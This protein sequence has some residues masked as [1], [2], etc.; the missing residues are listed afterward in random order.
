MSVPLRGPSPTAE[1]SG[2]PPRHRKT[3]IHQFRKDS[4]LTHEDCSSGATRLS[5]L[6][7]VNR[8]ILWA[9]HGKIQC[10]SSWWHLWVSQPKN[11]ESIAKC[12]FLVALSNSQLPFLR[13]CCPQLF[14][15]LFS[16]QWLEWFISPT[17]VWRL[18]IFGATSWNNHAIDFLGFQGVRDA[19]LNVAL[20]GVP[21]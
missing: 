14:I 15:V 4:F 20:V 21:S 12:F 7:T 5:L 10:T 11:P 1:L 16:A 8:I 2:M 3:C 13:E 9:V 18:C 17:Y 6:E 19:V